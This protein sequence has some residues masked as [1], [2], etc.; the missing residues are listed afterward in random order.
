MQIFPFFSL[1]L[2]DAESYFEANTWASFPGELTI[3][4]TQKARCKFTL[5][6]TICKPTAMPWVIKLGRAASQQVLRYLWAGHAAC[7]LAQPLS[8]SAHS[9]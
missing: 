8:E 3:Y 4:T 5:A 9:I 1:K 2:V 7:R 6:G